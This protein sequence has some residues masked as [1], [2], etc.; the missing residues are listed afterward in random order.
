MGFYFEGSFLLTRNGKFDN[1]I[2][3]MYYNIILYAMIGKSTL[4]PVF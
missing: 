1:F 3:N 4:F 2:I